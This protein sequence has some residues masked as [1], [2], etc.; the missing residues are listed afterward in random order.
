MFFLGIG[1]AGRVIIICLL[2][3]GVGISS[4]S[5]IARGIDTVHIVFSVELIT[6]GVSLD[7]LA[8]SARY[9]SFFGLIVSILQRA[10]DNTTAATIQIIINGI[11]MN[12]HRK[13]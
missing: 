3:C 6:G 8:D 7:V 2:G 10:N 1:V 12:T 11:A 9:E 13:Y 4:R 5:V